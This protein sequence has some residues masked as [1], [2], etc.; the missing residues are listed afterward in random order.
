MKQ[1]LTVEEASEIMG[2][3]KQ[4]MRIRIQRGVYPFGRVIETKGSKIKQYEVS[5]PKL[6]EYLGNYE[7]RNFSDCGGFDSSNANAS[8]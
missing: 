1:T 4:C 8:D 5:K 6:M 3:S 2:V 7:K